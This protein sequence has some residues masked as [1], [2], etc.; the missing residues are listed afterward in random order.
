MT[1][2][3]FRQR[4]S[5]YFSH[6]LTHALIK[7]VPQVPPVRGGIRLGNAKWKFRI[8]STQNLYIKYEK[9]SAQ[10][11]NIQDLAADENDEELAISKRNRYLYLFPNR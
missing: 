6:G 2:Y 3:G 11:C 5:L 4:Q 8:C 9:L 10:A 1:G 7:C